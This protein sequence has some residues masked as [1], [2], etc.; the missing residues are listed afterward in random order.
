MMSARHLDYVWAIEKESFTTPWSRESFE[1]ELDN[2]HAR[3]IIASEGADV[4]G[5]AGYWRI[6]DEA[7]V[8]NVAIKKDRRGMGYGKALMIRIMDLAKA[9][10]VLAMT[11]E[12]R[13]GNVTALRLYEKL[14]FQSAG[15]RPGYY[16]DN[17]EDAV[18]M[19]N[20]SY[21]TSGASGRHGIV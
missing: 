4:V 17:G 5:Y 10:G 8:T 3:Y 6:F 14:G 11:L 19:W 13:A 1:M 7:H 21:F 12:V 9:E 16:E 2:G 15:V 20:T 18:I